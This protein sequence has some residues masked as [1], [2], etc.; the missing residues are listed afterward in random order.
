MKRTGTRFQIKTHNS[1]DYLVGGVV[2]DREEQLQHNLGVLA[3][4]NSQ[5]ARILLDG[6]DVELNWFKQQINPVADEGVEGVGDNEVIWVKN[7][8]L[9]PHEKSSQD[10]TWSEI[11]RLRPYQNNDCR[12]SGSEQ[13]S[14]EY[15][16]CLKNI[17]FTCNF[18]EKYLNTKPAGVVQPVIRESVLALPSVMRM[19]EEFDPIETGTLLAYTDNVALTF[20]SRKSPRSALVIN[21]RRSVLEAIT[22]YDTPKKDFSYIS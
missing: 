9:I 11:R 5:L 7:Q 8:E 17:E 3:R 6:Y 15:L 22:C 14:E 10:F 20:L 19:M 2:V 1:Q 21:E 4:G 18:T 12:T 13:I 16:D